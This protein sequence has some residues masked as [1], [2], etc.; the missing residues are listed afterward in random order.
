[1]FI[2]KKYPIRKRPVVGEMPQRRRLDG[3]DDEN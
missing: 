2:V 3:E 1:M